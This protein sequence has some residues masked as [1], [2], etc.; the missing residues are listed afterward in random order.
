MELTDDLLIDHLYI[1][2]ENLTSF[3]PAT[4]AVVY[5]G[6]GGRVEA[7]LQF[8]VACDGDWYGPFCDVECHGRDDS[9]GHYQCNIYGVRE[10]IEGYQ[11]LETNCTEC[12]AA[13]GCS[14]CSSVT[15]LDK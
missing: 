5:E 13:E 3:S 4:P 6:E 10:C 11:N 8:N 15:L 14:K 7:E 2:I 9:G 12:M 1:E